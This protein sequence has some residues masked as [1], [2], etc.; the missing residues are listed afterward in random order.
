MIGMGADV[1]DDDSGRSSV[2]EAERADARTLP[3]LTS[4][5]ETLLL[6]ELMAELLSSE[7]CDPW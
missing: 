2:H 1:N 7:R 5:I 4:S 3:L 6:T